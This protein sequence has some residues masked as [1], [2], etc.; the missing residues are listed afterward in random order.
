MNDNWHHGKGAGVW[1]G[2]KFHIPSYTS[3]VQV[4]AQILE[5]GNFN[6][7]KSQSIRNLEFDWK[8]FRRGK[9]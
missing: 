4:I 9:Y 7:Y 6:L 2:D 3:G 5:T 8:N 1:E